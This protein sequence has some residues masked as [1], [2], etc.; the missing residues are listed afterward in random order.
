MYTEFHLNV[1][2]RVILEE[3]DLESVDSS[4]SGPDKAPFENVHGIL[5]LGLY[6]TI[7]DDR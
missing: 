4:R 5:T 2:G 7:L 6:C 3:A 1:Q